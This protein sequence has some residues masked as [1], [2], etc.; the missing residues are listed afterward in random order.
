MQTRDACGSDV[1]HAQHMHAACLQSAWT[2]RACMQGAWTQ[3]ACIQSA[4][5]QYVS[6]MNTVCM[7]H[8]HAMHATCKLPSLAQIMVKKN[9][10]II[11]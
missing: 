4:W 2:R 10:G 5:T 8:A 11:P 3:R 6:S 7:P 1:S 9:H